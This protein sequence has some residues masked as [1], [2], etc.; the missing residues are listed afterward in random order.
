MKKAILWLSHVF[1]K[2]LD[3]YPVFVKFWIVYSISLYVMRKSCN[4]THI[5]M[6]YVV[7]QLFPRF[8]VVFVI[9]R[10]LEMEHGVF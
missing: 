3:N 6:I 1:C 8:L 2:I 9:K 5:C 10:P 4:K 7:C